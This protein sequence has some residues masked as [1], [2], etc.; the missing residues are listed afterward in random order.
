MVQPIHAI[1]IFIWPADHI[2]TA[3]ANVLDVVH[4]RV[5]GNFG[6]GSAQIG[7]R[8]PVYIGISCQAAEILQLSR[9]CIKE[10]SKPCGCLGDIQVGSQLGVL[11]SNAHGAFA[12]VV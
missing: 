7:N 10:V 6:I 9:G 1:S 12:G 5:S 11:S 3:E 8:Q 4:I 2:V